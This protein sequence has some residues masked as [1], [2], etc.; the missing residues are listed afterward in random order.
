MQ[1][2]ASPD[3]HTG[4]TAVLINKPVKGVPSARP[5]WS[6]STLEEVDKKIIIR[7]FFS[8]DSPFA[9]DAPTISVSEPSAGGPR[10]P[11]RYA[12]PSEHAIGTAV[13]GSGV[14]SGGTG[15]TLEELAV[16]FERGR[17]GKHGIRE[18]VIEV[19]ERRCEVTDNADKNY[20]WLRWRH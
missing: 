13:T 14:G 16:H 17:P 7:N 11:G 9:S 10:D 18:K 1:S 12:L 5:A 8:A 3:F 2:G 19:V 15:L 20:R 4:V 6:P